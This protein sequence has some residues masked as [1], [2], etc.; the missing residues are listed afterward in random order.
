MSYILHKS[1]AIK[2]D[3]M[4]LKEFQ[5]Q[6]IGYMQR[7]NCTYAKEEEID[8]KNGKIYIL[9]SDITSKNGKNLGELIGLYYSLE[10]GHLN[11]ERDDK[12]YIIL[13]PRRKKGKKNVHKDRKETD[14]RSESG[15]GGEAAG[16]SGSG[17]V[18]GSAGDGI[19][20]GADDDSDL[21]EQPRVE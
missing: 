9:L 15:N 21:W 16:D 6:L 17:P 5:P 18:G 19:N 3:I 7:M 11:D 14:G 1:P 20:P 12:F 8:P 2:M 13:N 10:W 4:V